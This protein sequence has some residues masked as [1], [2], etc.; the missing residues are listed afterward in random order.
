MLAFGIPVYLA[1]H[2]YIGYFKI[3]L[4]FKFVSMICTLQQPDGHGKIVQV[5]PFM[6]KINQVP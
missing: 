6:K 3:Q 5:D 2:K 1:S 4:Y